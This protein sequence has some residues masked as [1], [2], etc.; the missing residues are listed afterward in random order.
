MKIH[1]SLFVVLLL[2]S[3]PGIAQQ[4]KQLNNTPPAK[5]S[6]DQLTWL[7]GHWKGEAFGGTA[8][9][10]WSP[11]QAGTMMFSFR[12]INNNKVSFYEFGFITQQDET[13]VLKLKHFGADLT[14]WEEKDKWVE[15]KLVDISNETAWFEGFTIEKVSD[16][17]INMYV[18]IDEEEEANEVRFNYHRVNP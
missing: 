6:L 2:L 5:G 16:A 12:L 9:E 18:L 7:E 4:T 1:L 8:E 14:G 3:S 15:F 11:A 13:L 17:E 10:I